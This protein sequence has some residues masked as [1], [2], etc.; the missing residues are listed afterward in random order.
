MYLANPWGLLGLLGLPVIAFIHLYHRRFPPQYVAGLFLWVTETEVRMPGRRLD[1]LP[2][3]TTLLL[4]LLTALVLSLVLADPRLSEWD[5][6]RHLV[7]VL[8]HSASMQGQPEGEVSFR[9]A[10]IQEL[11]SR[12]SKLPRHSAVTLIRTGPTPL[13]L[14][15]RGTIEE[16]K[17]ALAAWQPNAPRHRFAPAWEELGMQLVEESGSI[18]FLTDEL[19]DPKDVPRNLEVLSFGRKLENIAFNAARWTFDS[20]AKQG[21]L[22]IR[23]HNYG[24]DSAECHLVI[25]S[26]DQE[27]SR[28]NL[29]IPA[30]H[31]VALNLPI[32][33]RLGTLQL[34][35]EKN[36]DG[37]RLDNQIQLVEPQV[38][39]VKVALEGLPEYP[40]KQ[41]ERVLRIT[42]DISV[43]TQEPH[44]LFDKASQLPESNG[45]LWWVGIGPIS[46]E[47]AD[48]KA[49]KD[50]EGPYLVDRRNPIVDGVSLGGV[51]WAGV[52][53]TKYEMMPLISSGQAT[54]LG[55]L[56]GTQTTAFLMNIDLK[57]SNLVESPDWP[58]FINN[59][60]EQRRDSLPGLRRWNYR[61]G[62]VVR[63]RL[64][65]PP[66]RAPEH[67]VTL[68]SQAQ[69]RKIP[70]DSLIEIGDLNEPGLFE[71][72][73]GDGLLGR[74]AVNFF[75]PA[76]SD[77]RQLRPGNIP[78]A[79][80]AVTSRIAAD[81]P[82]T[83]A[84]WLGTILILLL[85]FADWLVLKPNPVR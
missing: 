21:Q 29:S 64:F 41:I 71:I 5:E 59:L 42:P 66:D 19:P 46:P 60:V 68:V 24:F 2:I 37:L 67:A 32:P 43:N 61:S 83:W 38:R 35:L 8:N 49:A 13:T 85:L 48:L 6:V 44:I 72:R 3:T 33:G 55:Q 34:I 84:L 51:I 47:E 36:G 70:R 40:R 79:E 14:V 69:T 58:V 82:Y 27:V 54:L 11:E 77:L 7:A 20:I 76:E 15:R 28:Q 31:A 50:L 74:F 78:A 39:P 53:P 23:I 57:R 30:D 65:D 75:D 63:F 10:A 73:D 1:R 4:E 81:L 25:K 17:A 45:A 62:E 56:K 9:E 22:F 26:S 18:L 52:Q 16:A 80:N 12:F